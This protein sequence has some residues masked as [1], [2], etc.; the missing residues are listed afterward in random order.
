M[1]TAMKPW[2]LAGCLLIA[3]A[4]QG[5]SEPEKATAER[6]GAR[7]HAL[8]LTLSTETLGRA[9][10]D[11]SA[12]AFI[13]TPVLENFTG[14]LEGTTITYDD[15]AKNSILQGTT[16]TLH[17]THCEGAVGEMRVTID[18]TVTSPYIS[19]LGRLEVS[20]SGDLRFV[21]ASEADVRNNIHEVLLRIAP[22]D[23]AVK[24]KGVLA[25]VDIRQRKYF[26]ELLADLALD[27]TSESALLIKIPVRELLNVKIDVPVHGDTTINALDVHDGDNRDVDI[28]YSISPQN[29][30]LTKSVPFIAM[31]PRKT[32]IWLLAG[33]AAPVPTANYIP[34]KPLTPLEWNASADPVMK[35]VLAYLIATQS[36]MA[37][38]PLPTSSKALEESLQTLVGKLQTHFTNDPGTHFHAGAAAATDPV[39]YGYVRGRDLEEIS[40]QFGTRHVSVQSTTI[41]N[42]GQFLDLT[43]FNSQ[44]VGKLSFY[45]DFRGA[46]ALSAAADLTLKNPTWNKNGLQGHIT[47]DTKATIKTRAQIE[48]GKLDKIPVAGSLLMKT[49]GMDIDIAGNSRDNVDFTLSPTFIMSDDHSASATSL[50]LHTNPA[51]TIPIKFDTRSLNRFLF[52]WTGG[53]IVGKVVGLVEPTR[54]PDTLGITFNYSVSKNQLAP[55]P[56]VRTHEYF[57]S[58]PSPPKIADSPWKISIGAHSAKVKTEPRA[59]GFAITGDGLFAVSTIAA[60]VIRP[61]EETAAQKAISEDN[62]R[63]DQLITQA[64]TTAEQKYEAAR[65]IVDNSLDIDIGPLG[66]KAALIEKYWDYLK[67]GFVLIKDGYVEAAKVILQTGTFVVSRTSDAIKLVTVQPVGIVAGGAVGAAHKVENTRNQIVTDIKHVRMPWRKKKH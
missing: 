9:P 18:A 15:A 39:L 40:Q 10:E 46:D 49:S 1:Y 12:G 7:W 29:I 57:V 11:W 43:A 22:T 21:S 36:P 33:N 28:D 8:N 26:S 44:L 37:H 20:V 14:L 64:S 3:I 67:D 34:A 42:E 4:I 16:I 52:D 60:T 17:K 30:L 50:A 56:L 54:T 2:T 63:Y 25:L 5:C 47:Y 32:G 62:S 6:L 35:D 41:T 65:D 24:G 48:L 27:K 61:E 59:P 58:L 45:V 66:I 51:Q 19:P 13:S 23:I 38:F 31:I 53:P 55:I